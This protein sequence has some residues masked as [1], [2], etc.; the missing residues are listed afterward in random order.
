M[1]I[2][3]TATVDI[4]PN[5]QP[6]TQGLLK[7]RAQLD[8]FARGPSIASFGTAMKVGTLAIGVGLGTAMIN[9]AKKAANFEETLNKVKVTFG[10]SGSSGVIGKVNDLADR[11]GLLRRSTLDAAA[12]FG[13]FGQ[14]AG[15]SKQQSAEFAKQLIDLGADLAS[16]HNISRESAFEKIQSGL[17]GQV[18]PLRE[19]GIFLGEDAVKAKALAM[20]LGAVGKELTDQEKI[21]ARFALIM[22]QAGPAHG[23]LERT[24]SSTHNQMMKFFGDIENTVGRIGKEFTPALLEAMHA[25]RELGKVL[26][27]EFSKSGI[28]IAKVGEDV[29]STAES[30]KSL[31]KLFQVMRKPETAGLIEKHGIL[32]G[33]TE[34]VFQLDKTPGGGKGLPATLPGILANRRAAQEAT[35]EAERR[36]AIMRVMPPS[37]RSLAELEIGPEKKEDEKRAEKR[38]RTIS[39]HMRRLQADQDR[40]TVASLG[41]VAR[42]PQGAAVIQ[43][44]LANRILDRM[45]V[46]APGALSTLRNVLGGPITPL[47]GAGYGGEALAIGLRKVFG[48]VKPPEV[49]AYQDQIDKLKDDLKQEKRLKE[50]RLRLGI[51]DQPSTMFTDPAE[52]A[53]SMVQGILG[54]SND[55]VKAIEDS[56]KVLKE[57]RDKLPGQE[58]VERRRGIFPIG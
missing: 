18:R 16:F 25:A 58:K 40:A 23:D 27:T 14:A 4:I 2:L 50:A 1:G 26:G 47:M 28:T 22:E 20:G 38:E 32:G 21:R 6:L 52:Y 46:G 17:V 45:R 44:D 41:G 56:I 3:A 55:Q 12:N 10:T 29:K 31:F 57:I 51:S 42:G 37:L 5:L 13:L 19:I 24:A 9:A 35:A 8:S 36:A 34:A 15:M 39:A 43:R 54:R 11:F 30:W 7:A 53:R 33:I 49:Q 48:E